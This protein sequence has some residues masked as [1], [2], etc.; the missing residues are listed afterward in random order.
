MSIL[1]IHPTGNK[2]FFYLIKALKKNFLLKAIFLS[3][4][5]NSNN[6]VYSFLPKKIRYYLK[7]RD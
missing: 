3:F 6:K 5:I 4:N 1:S 7:R 2:N